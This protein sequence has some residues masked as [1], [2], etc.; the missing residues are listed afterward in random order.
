MAKLVFGLNQSLDGYVGHTAF[1]PDSTLFR[2]LI[3]D[4]QTQTGSVNGSRLYDIMRYWDDDQPEW[5]ADERAYAAAWRRQP[6]WGVSRTLKG[7]GPNATLEGHRGPVQS[8][9][10]GTDSDLVLSGSE[11]GTIKVWELAGLS[12]PAGGAISE[13]EPAGASRPP[14][15]DVI[16]VS[17]Q[18]GAVVCTTTIDLRDLHRI[19][20]GD[21]AQA[22]ITTDGHGPF[23]MSGDGAFVVG[24]VGHTRATQHSE[25]A[26]DY[27]PTLWATGARRLS[28]HVCG[29]RRYHLL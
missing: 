29:G 18:T 27:I 16:A 8:L 5:E 26:T 21:P 17:A 3:E 2:H 1:A 6:K 19:I 7:V 11:D 20:P 24:Y 4:A 22:E 10:I 12:D 28:G 25:D 23:A 9:A 15:R 14:I 13:R